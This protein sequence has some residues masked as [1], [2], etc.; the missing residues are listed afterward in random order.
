ME[1]KK[2]R[3]MTFK[4][5][6]EK[7]GDIATAYKTGLLAIKQSDRQSIKV[8]DTRSLEGSVDIDKATSAK[9][10]NESRWDYV[11]GHDK[12]V[13]FVEVHPAK[14]GNVTEMMNKLSWIKSWLKTN[15][16]DLNSYSSVAPVFLWAATSSGIHIP[17]TS[18]EY[19]K[20][21][22]LNIIP[23]FPQLIG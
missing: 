11:I 10:P 6:I 21:A 9:Y 15:A 2:E 3:N 4:E 23:K 7:T 14:T 18:K 20:V 16:P 5:A 17:K 12:R 22:K 1:N 13:Y 19:R 8:K